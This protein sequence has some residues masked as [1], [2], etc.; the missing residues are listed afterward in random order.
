MSIKNPNEWRFDESAR[1]LAFFS[2]KK[3]VTVGNSLIEE[4]KLIS[5]ENNNANIRLCLHNNPEDSLHDMIILEYKDKKSREPHKHILKNETIHMME[6]E[7]LMLIFDDL[8]NLNEKILLKPEENF[9]YRSPRNLHHLWLP[10]TDYV[11]YREIKQGPFNREE[12]IPADWDHE[13]I[14]KKHGL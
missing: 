8:G 12:N 11:I 10:Q 3:S 5:K 2:L 6:G 13:E 7:M 1:T 4:L 9:A 14:L